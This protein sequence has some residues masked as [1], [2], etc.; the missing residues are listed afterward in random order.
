MS[1]DNTDNT[2]E[3]SEQHEL[4]RVRWDGAL[5][6]PVGKTPFGFFD[7]DQS[8]IGF[9][10]RAADWAAKRLGYPIVD[11]EMID[12]QFYACLEESVTEYSA[13]V[14]QFSIKQNL[15]SLKGTTTSVNL[16]TSVMQTQPLPFYLKLSEAYGAEVGVGG[17]VDWRKQSLK[18]KEGVQ[19]YDL[20]GLFNQYYIDPRTGE[21]KLE[22]IEV[23]RIWH[24][25]PPAMNKI[26]DPMATSGMSMSNML[27]EFGWSGMSPLG[28]Q[29][30]MRPVNEDLM[31]LQAIEFNE[32]LRRSAYGFEVINNKLTILPVPQKDFT[33]WF[34]YVYKRE[35]DIAAVQGY[36][37]ADEFNTM[38]KTQ[39]AVSEETTQQV[40]I[41]ETS[42][43]IDDG[44]NTEDD[45]SEV[46]P[47]RPL[48]SSPDS[49][50]DVSNAP[51]AF[52]NFGTIN[53]VGKRWIMK[54]YL[55]LC[56][57]LLGSIRAKY[58]TI[59]IPGG[60][61]SLDGDALRS[62]AQQEKEQLITELR[63]DLEVTSRSTTSEQ[64]NQVADNLQENLR[65]VPNFLYIG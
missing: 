12:V 28:T 4:E 65:K 49:V 1:E 18:V 22:R 16:T 8:F 24:H 31:R 44:T 55:A 23:K 19:T 47:N 7:S 40:V 42:K 26:Y 59:P 46:Y 10:P 39:T 53:D 15:Y 52:H 56:K 45:M 36:V 62:E 58:Q 30:L 38:P 25:P 6:S 57:E 11:I 17:N 3:S 27:G 32:Q 20:Q 41:N 51:Y 14:N 48:E 34:D 33:L 29:F 61:T 9:A 2:N 50:T 64:L 21:K 43:G 35:R 5:S 60:E 54:Y 63:E 37:D 13:Q